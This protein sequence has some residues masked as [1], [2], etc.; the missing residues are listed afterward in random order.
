MRNADEDHRA[1]ATAVAEGVAPPDSSRPG[2]LLPS[3]LVLGSALGAVVT[4][5]PDEYLG[6]L[7]LGLY[8]VPSHV[9]VSPFPHEPVLLLIARTHNPWA[10]AFVSIWGALVAA[11]LDFRYTL[12]L[13]HRPGVRSRY[14][15]LS[16][17]RK[18]ARWFGVAPFLTLVVTGFTPIPFYPFKF[19]ALASGYPM[20]R[21][22][23]ALAV[24]RTPRYWMLAYLGYVLQPPNWVLALL[25]LAILT[26]ALLGSRSR[27]AWPG[28]EEDEAPDAGEAG[29]G[30]G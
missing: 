9:F 20:G 4:A 23:L 10:C 17:Y 3:V 19:L 12:P 26:M 28:G 15:D 6:I 21:Y 2:W 18:S 11:L 14:V 29:R 24:G 8:T 13:L 25:A 27:R 1:G 7:E 16:L 22:M 5:T 30:D